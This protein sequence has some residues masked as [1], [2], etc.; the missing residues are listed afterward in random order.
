MFH[1]KSP[2]FMHLKGSGMVSSRE[3]GCLSRIQG[4]QGAGFPDPEPHTVII[5]NPKNYHQALGNL[6]RDVYLPEW[7][8]FSAGWLFRSTSCVINERKCTVLYGTAKKLLPCSSVCSVLYLLLIIQDENHNFVFS[9]PSKI[10]GL[11]G[12]DPFVRCAGTDPDPSNIRQ[13]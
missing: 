2:A 4:Q 9:V 13:K 6:I 5:F 8:S 11:P 1:Q 7:I 12:P 10:S 3:P